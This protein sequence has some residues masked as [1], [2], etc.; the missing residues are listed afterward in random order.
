V[1]II[2][3]M[4]NAEPQVIIT[5]DNLNATVDAQVYFKTKADEKSVKSSVY[6]VNNYRYQ[7]VNL[8]RTTLRISLEL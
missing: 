8:A 7:I 2:E 1:K 4:F 3:Q 5:N 6:N